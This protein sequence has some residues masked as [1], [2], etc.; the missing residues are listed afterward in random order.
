MILKKFTL[1]ILLLPY[2]GYAQ[3]NRVQ[4][5][6]KIVADFQNVPAMKQGF[7]SWCVIDLQTG[8]IVFQANAEKSLIPA[9]CLK[10]VT[11]ATALSRLGEDF[12]CET[13]LGFTGEINSQGVLQG[14]LIIRGG[15][16]PT[17]GS[18]RFESQMKYDELIDFWVNEV[19][20]VGIRRIEGHVIGDDRFFDNETT[21]RTWL[22]EDLGNYYGAGASG[23]CLNENMFELVLAPGKQIGEMAKVLRTEPHISGLIFKN[24]IKTGSSRSGD[25]GYIF[26]APNQWECWLRGSIPGARREFSIKGAMPNPAKTCAQLLAERLKA[27]NISING[28]VYTGDEIYANAADL[29]PFTQISSLK[30]PPLKEMI[31]WLNKKSINLYAEQMVKLLGKMIKGEGSYKAGL[32]VME[33]YLAELNIPADGLHLYD[34]SGLS[35][36]DGLTT[37]QLAKLLEQMKPTNGFNSFYQSL[38]VAGNPKD[39]GTVNYWCH[40]TVAAK[41]AR[42][43]TGS[44]ERVRN[45]AGYVRDAGGRMLCF[46]MFANNYD[47]KSRV[48]EKFHEKLVVM[49]AELGR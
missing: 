22:W 19:Q 2:L 44:L 49:L 39:E 41:N 10:L 6:E 29:S 28:G 35:R 31:F 18:D 40:G 7:W 1:L 45:H 17:L 48:I 16:D 25:N 14:N 13:A 47:C 36:M 26:C 38:P 46:A 8:E 32:E 5:I 33:E 23:L 30:S 42:I 15:G 20:K 21:P 12:Q 9:S 24:E 34:G 3:S 37:L 27:Y 11:S 43:K 4:T